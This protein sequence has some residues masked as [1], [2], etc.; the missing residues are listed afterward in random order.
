[1]AVMHEWGARRPVG[2]NGAFTQALAAAATAAGVEIRTGAPA[3]EILLA[4][5]RAAASSP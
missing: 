3:A 2:G 4:G 1:M 5:D